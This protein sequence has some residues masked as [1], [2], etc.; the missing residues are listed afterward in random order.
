MF[1]YLARL[2][3]LLALAS[4][5]SAGVNAQQKPNPMG[6]PNEFV[7]QV[8]DQVLTALKEDTAA[9]SGDIKR[10]NQI[11]D[12]MI[13]PYVNFEKRRASLRVEI[14]DCP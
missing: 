14:T 13:L 2:T 9:R 6:S 3:L 11:V 4:G 10:I 8:A 7:Q 12:E 5:L 1:A